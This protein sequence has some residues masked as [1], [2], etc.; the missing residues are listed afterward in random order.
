MDYKEI[1]YKDSVEKQVT[2]KSDDGLIDIG[3]GDFEGETMELTESVCDKDELTF[4]A[5]SAA[6]LSFT[7]SGGFSLQGKWLNVDIGLK[8]EDA[9]ASPYR[10][11]RYKVN[12]DKPTADRTS[13]K[14]IAYDALYDILQADVA[15][16]YNTILPEDDSR[17]YLRDF[18]DSFFNHFGIEQ[19]DITLVNDDM[20]VEKTDKAGEL[21]GAAVINCICEI[22]GCMGHI[23]REVKFEYIY[24]EPISAPDDISKSLYTSAAYEDYIVQPI[25]KLQIRQEEDDIG[26]IVG[27]GSNSYIIEDN[28]LVYGKSSAELTYIANNIFTKIKGLA[29]RPFTVECI[30]NPC[31]PVGAPVRVISTYATIDSYVFTRTLKGVQSL[32]DTYAA[33][34][35]EH[36]TGK[37]NSIQKQIIQ[38]KGRSNVLSRTIEE[39]K[40]TISDIEQGLKNEI[41]ATAS[42]FDVKLQNLQSEIDGQIEVINGHGQ[43]ALDNYPAYNWTSGPRTGDKL[44]EGLR[45]T[46]SNEVYRKHQRTLFFDEATATTYR[47][48]KRMMCGYGSRWETRSILCCRSR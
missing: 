31:I 26:V 38:L 27:D 18:R 14:V 47:F 46:Y 24:L 2:I 9:F 13:R 10:L 32:S 42:E 5:C 21:S 4:G 36:R 30:G 35:N 37:V 43:P 19:E 11:G 41:T 6:Q 16:W 20:W 28:F 17:V 40:N 7:V 34:G 3:N 44:V 8:S 48:I 45:F 12:S 25:D 15:G 23:D 33:A 39:T 1:F 29:Y 22:N